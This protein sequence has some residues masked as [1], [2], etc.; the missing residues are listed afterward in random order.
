MINYAMLIITGKGLHGV[1]GVWEVK[2]TW[3]Q[4]WTWGIVVIGTLTSDHLD[5]RY[6]MKLQMIMYSIR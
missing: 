5:D 4:C 6:P 3:L 2:T 1:M